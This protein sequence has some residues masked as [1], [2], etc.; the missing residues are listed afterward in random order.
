MV[1]VEFKY[2]DQLIIFDEPEPREFVRLIG[3]LNRNIEELADDHLNS[4]TKKSIMVFYLVIIFQKSLDYI[5][6]LK[7]EFPFL[8]PTQEIKVDA[9][10]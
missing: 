2:A 4:Q 7:K 8:L 1:G 5:E 10:S 3:R 6:V 9:N